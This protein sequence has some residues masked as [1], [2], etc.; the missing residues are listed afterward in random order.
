M[1]LF[2][3]EG[4]AILAQ[5]GIPVPRSFLL[6]ASSEEV[7]IPWPV[8]LK[9]QTLTG[10]RGKAGGVRV[11]T[12]TGQCESLA[13]EI[14]GM[15][16]AGHKVHAVLAEE[17]INV[18]R[19]FYLSLT[20][21]GA[22]SK[23]LLVLSGSGGMEI[24]AIAKSHPEKII[25]VE[26]DPLI[27]IK[28]YQIRYSA[29]AAGIPAPSSF[30]R[31]IVNLY[32]LFRETDAALVEINPL[33]LTEKGLIALDC[34]VVLD[35]QAAFR[36]TPLYG[37]IR[38]G[39][40]RFPSYREAEP[41]GTTITFVPLDGTVGLISDGAGTGMLALD[42]IS[43]AGGRAACF[44]ELGGITNPRVMYQAMQ[45]ALANPNV[46]SLLIVLIGGFNRMD[47]MAE[48]IAQ[49]KR[50]FGISVPVFTRMCG[51][52]EETG[53]EIM[54]SE[55]LPVYDQLEKAVSDAVF[56]PVH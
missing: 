21:Q 48:G 29:K 37:R 50:E 51:T 14:L 26:I 15:S 24:E 32:R 20:L 43:D 44:C 8:V 23:P 1:N 12:S 28:P 36:L 11:C 5:Y 55:G 22:R 13:K 33:A 38:E 7:P 46:N 6:G 35:D 49:Y 27:G 42:L 31:L 40:A 56:V 45:M 47:E 39:R 30:L 52:M 54:R 25:K 53:K 3:F 17:R 4:K 9:A 34:K 41:D 18:L 16:I 2:E 10:G 19:E